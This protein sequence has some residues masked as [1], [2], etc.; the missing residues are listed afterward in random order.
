MSMQPSE[1]SSR[2]PARALFLDRDGVINV[3]IGY[4]H[5]PDQCTFITGIFDVV[6]RARAL[7]YEIIVVTNQAGIAR[8]YYS[9]QVFEAFTQWMHAQF[10]ERGAAL[11]QVYHC[12]HHPDVGSPALRTR[13][14]CRK[15]A[16]G[17]LLRA[18]DDWHIDLAASILVGDSP[19]DIGAA[20]AAGVTRRV[21]FG[22]RADTP[23]QADLDCVRAS[24]MHDIAAML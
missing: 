19:S 4:L 2:P 9:E 8:G 17:M 20:I 24:D 7:D 10:A 12:P 15:P 13:C 21:L 22:S 3:D 6:R 14:A 11:T 23:Y 18:A 16:P 5:R 1:R